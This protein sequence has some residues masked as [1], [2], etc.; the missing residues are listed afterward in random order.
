M[1][2]VANE[3]SSLIS[4]PFWTSVVEYD[5]LYDGNSEDLSNSRKKSQYCFNHSSVAKRIF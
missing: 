5:Y 1:H 3:P 4:V 2:T